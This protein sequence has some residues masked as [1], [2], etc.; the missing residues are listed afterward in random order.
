PSDSFIVCSVVR[1]T[2]TPICQ[3]TKDT[4]QPR[5]VRTRHS[6]WL[7]Y[8]SELRNQSTNLYRN[9][10]F[11]IGAGLHLRCCDSRSSKLPSALLLY[12]LF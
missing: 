3:I 5:T 8:Q 12:Y 9:G 10:K 11:A 7:P 1:V 4:E 6:I 2:W